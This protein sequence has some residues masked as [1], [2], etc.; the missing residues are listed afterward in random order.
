M[1]DAAEIAEDNG[2]KRSAGPVW[3][4]IGG[5]IGFVIAMTV[6]WY[7][8]SHR[9]VDYA[10]ST[11]GEHATSFALKFKGI[12]N[13]TATNYVYRVVGPPGTTATISYINQNGSSGDVKDVVLPWSIAT[14]SSAGPD[15]PAD[16]G[17]PPYVY[18]HTNASGA[19]AKITCQAFGDGKLAD[20]ETSNAGSGIVWCGFPYLHSMPANRGRS[21]GVGLSV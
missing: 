6:L 10:G 7:L 15:L 8:V 5:L 4:Y 3:A 12:A 2:Y 17:Q 18:V 21:Q 1:S 14:V 19:N 16:A 9:G 13:P 20:Q 11:P